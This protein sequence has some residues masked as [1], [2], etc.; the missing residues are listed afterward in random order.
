M[1]RDHI[2]REANIVKVR[3][4]VVV[5][6]LERVQGERVWMMQLVLCRTVEASLEGLC[7]VSSAAE[8]DV[9]RCIDYRGDQDEFLVGGCR[10]E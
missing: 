1:L 9:S 2:I 4:F 8:L 3:I 5:A 7:S 6:Q 10:T